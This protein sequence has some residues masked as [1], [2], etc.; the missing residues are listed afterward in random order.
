M[1]IARS[2]R[3]LQCEILRDL[4]SDG[5]LGLVC[6]VPPSRFRVARH[7]LVHTSWFGVL[8]QLGIAIL[9]AEQGEYR[10]TFL[11]GH[12]PCQCPSGRVDA[13][14]FLPKSSTA[15]D[16]PTPYMQSVPTTSRRRNTAISWELSGMMRS[17]SRCLGRSRAREGIYES[18][19]QR[20][21]IHPQVNQHLRF[22]HNGNTSSCVNS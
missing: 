5:G 12:P 21:C 11:R 3:G 10:E 6:G 13:V 7:V 1:I 22:F 20:V 14:L 16:L 4:N 17:C 2:V 9:A 18:L 8:F 15:L 19:C